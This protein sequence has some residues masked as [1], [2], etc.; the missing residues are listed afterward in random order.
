LQPNQTALVSGAAGAVGRCAVFAAKN[1]GARVIAGVLR[2][3]LD[4]AESI[5]AD[6]AIALDDPPA[7][8]RLASV[9]LVANTLRGASATALLPKVKPGGTFASVT[10][11]PDGV[12]AFPNVRVVPFVSKQD[13]N[14]IESIAIAV[15]AGKLTIPIGLREQLKNAGPAQ[16]AFT[17]GGIG[18]VLLVP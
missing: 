6:E 17:R 18:K 14:V 2:S 8:E 12:E 1:I 10:G 5:G 15:S 9:D 13:R 16:A 4:Q 7:V 3:Q 11:A